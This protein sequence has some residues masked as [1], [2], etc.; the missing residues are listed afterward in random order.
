MMHLQDFVVSIREA[1][2]GKAFREFKTDNEPDIV[3]R[4][5]KIHVPFNQEYE[6]M[7]KNMKN[8]RRSV[9]IDID[10]TE[11]GT[12]VIGEGTK[13]NP[14]EVVLER[15]MDSDKRFK[16]LR[17]GDDGVADPTNKEN[18]IIRVKV[19]DEKPRPRP[20]RH[21][22]RDKGPLRG[23]GGMSAQSNA[24][25]V[26]SCNT[27]NYLSIDTGASEYSS[28][29]AT[30]EGSESDQKFTS[31][32]WYGDS[33]NIMLFEFFIIGVEKPVS[34]TVN[35]KYCT[36]CGIKLVDGSKFCHDCGSE[37]L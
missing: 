37:I 2:K 34:K 6:F 29:A 15:F 8:I 21:L 24:G 18:G 13:I 22:Y 11:V 19:I 32:T 12:W 25:P 3:G 17:L 35:I 27:D 28:N 31:T 23:C 20:R 26:F 14:Y 16:V 9:T 36:N 30:G 7:F 33:N 4:S 5:R 1:G 10:G